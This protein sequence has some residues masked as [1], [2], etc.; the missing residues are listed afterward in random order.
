MFVCWNSFNKLLKVFSPAK[1]NSTNFLF[2]HAYHFHTYALLQHFLMPEEQLKWHLK[3][4]DFSNQLLSYFGD[5]VLNSLELYYVLFKKKVSDKNDLKLN[6]PI[7]I[8]RYF[9]E[10]I[11]SS[12]DINIFIYFIIEHAMIASTTAA[13]ITLLFWLHPHF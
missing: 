3:M 10:K 2:T 12:C 8:G 6:M 4:I 13:T 7:K 1:W 11:N 9:Q 5:S